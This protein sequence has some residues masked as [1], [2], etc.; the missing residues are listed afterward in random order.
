MSML[1]YFVNLMFWLYSQLISLFRRWLEVVNE[2]FHFHLPSTNLSVKHTKVSQR[3]LFEESAIKIGQL[4]V[5]EVNKVT[6]NIRNGFA[7]HRGDGIVIKGI[8][9]QSII[10]VIFQGTITLYRKMNREILNHMI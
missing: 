6:R 10:V 4:S 8:C 9:S 7:R 1:K 3:D 2:D 5:W